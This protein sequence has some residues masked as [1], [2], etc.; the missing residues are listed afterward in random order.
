M[1]KAAIQQIKNLLSDKSQKIVIISHVNPDGDAIGSSMG[2]YHF[3]KND[4][5]THVSVVSP[6]SFPSFIS[7][8]P[9]TQQ[10]IIATREPNKALGALADADIIFCL[11]FN[12]MARTDQLQE[13]LKKSSATKILIDHHPDPHDQFDVVFSHVSASSTAELIYEFIVA[14]GKEHL[15]DEHI[16]QCLYTGIIT[17][18]GSFS[19]A[20]NN[21]KTYHITAHLISLGIDG[22]KIHRKIY[23]TYSEDR[24][25][26]LGHCLSSNLKV[27]LPC[28]TAFIY[29]SCED[30]KRFNYQEGDTEGVVNYA[31]SIKGIELGAIFIEKKDIIKISFRSEGTI[32]VNTLARDY[33]NGG[34]H[35]NASGGHSQ[36]NLEKTIKDFEQLIANLSKDDFR[37]LR[38]IKDNH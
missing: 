22:E 25:R 11:D 21:P 27:M 16:A 1:D 38:V 19:Y 20:C 18:T 15:L 3:L 4:N 9:G 35:K 7:W 26:L 33:F 31:L 36:Q 23:D 29:L 30:L 14:L 32:N 10:I 34:G 13:A 17:D 37:T 12:D 2:V 5:F 24:L 28:K 8:M 6:G